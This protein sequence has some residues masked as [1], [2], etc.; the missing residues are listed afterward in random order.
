MKTLAHWFAPPGYDRALLRRD[1]V[2]GLTV[3]SVAVPQAMAY[4]LL[5]GVPPV[6]GLYTAVVVAALRSLFGSSAHLINGPT[7]VI[8]LVVF[9]VVAGVGAGPDDPGRIGLVAC[10]A[11]LAGLIQIGLAFLKL[12]GLGR[13]FSEAVLLGFMAGAG[14]LEALT[15]V[16]TALG[17]RLAGTG[18]DQ[19]LRRFWLTCSQ[20]GPADGPSLAV[21]LGT[22]ALLAGLHR[23]SAR[24]K[25]RLPDMFLSL[26]LVSLVVGLLHL[27]PAGGGVGR[28]HL[29]GNV[30]P[31]WPPAPPSGVARHL[32]SLG[33]AALAIAL[34]GLAEAVAMAKA[35]AG[36]SGQAL[37]YNRECLAQGLANVGGGLFGCLPGSGSL[38]RSAVNY[39]AGA[40][41]R[42]S[43]V[44]SAAGVAAA[45]GLFAPLAGRVPPP[46]LAG[47]LLWTAWRL[48]D[49]RRLW[50]RL[51]SS[52]AAATE[53]LSTALVGVLVG[54]EYAL[55]AGLAASLL[56]R[57]PPPRH[58]GIWLGRIRGER[59]FG[60]GRVEFTLPP[61]MWVLLLFRPIRPS[62]MS[63]RAP[64]S[65]PIPRPVAE[66]VG[67]GRD[68][69]RKCPEN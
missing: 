33:G 55:L 32:G 62:G 67:T 56:V 8:S 16:P 1:T 35:L 14:L 59:E 41:T 44:F 15:Q 26:A 19:L 50:S 5:A 48:A 42:L 64:P 63:F 66:S 54:I 3:A 24:W 43:G 25:V 53:I 52:R 34:L 51:R 4:A 27:D 13:Y 65:P 57:L 58:F 10:L 47:I 23:L 37:D 61:G 18:K 28:L 30:L 29:G 40:A 46:A 45:L 2:A 31:S 22:L 11:V 6:Y 21:T 60:S 68:S 36:W 20:G 9:G 17:L 39:H 38:S 12:G 7:S 69:A 49:P